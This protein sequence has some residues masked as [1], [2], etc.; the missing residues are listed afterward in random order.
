MNSYERRRLLIKHMESL[1]SQGMGCLGCQGTCCTFESNSMML[2]PL[3]AVEIMGYLKEKALLTTDLKEKLLKTQKENR[4][5]NKPLANQRR[6]YLR[7]TYT[8][9]FFG[10]MELGCPL[11]RE[12]KPYGCLA[13]DSHHRELKASVHCYS[14]KELMIK[15]EA[16]FPEEVQ[17]NEE[18]RKKYNLYWEKGPIPSALLDLWEHFS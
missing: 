3:E 13:F 10:H 12:I 16:E 7:K 14:E 6:S 1:E 8:C 18:L 5:E 2:T 11:P 15:R 4:L 17:I 9:P